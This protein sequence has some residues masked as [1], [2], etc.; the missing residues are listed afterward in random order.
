MKSSSRP[1]DRWGEGGHPV[2][3]AANSGHCADLDQRPQ[4]PGGSGGRSSGAAQDE[5]R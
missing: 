5:N 1:R 2:V 3:I 4:C